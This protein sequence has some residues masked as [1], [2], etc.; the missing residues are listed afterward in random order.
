MTLS[1]TLLN[2]LRCRSVGFWVNSQSHSQSA[3]THAQHTHTNARAYTKTG[4][5]LYAPHIYTGMGEQITN[6]YTVNIEKTKRIHR[7]LNV[8]I[9][10]MQTLQSLSNGMEGKNKYQCRIFNLFENDKI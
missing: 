4:K 6:L 10:L 5:C 7:M 9:C 1:Y 3:R 2:M 8:S